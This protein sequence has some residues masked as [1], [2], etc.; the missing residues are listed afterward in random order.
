MP[1]NIIKESKNP[2]IKSLDGII[3]SG[4]VE[5]WIDTL[6]FSMERPILG[7]G[8]MADRIFLNYH[9]DG[10]KKFIEPVSNAYIY[11]LVSGG[12]PSLFLFGCECSYVTCLKLN[13]FDNFFFI[14]VNFP[15]KPDLRDKIG[16]C[17]LY[18]KRLFDCP[19]NSYSENIDPL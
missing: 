10:K 18:L 2:L 14:F 3:F 17:F 13:I 9:K 15:F 1:T 7:Y 6:K 4:R 19:I 16:I 12:I 11:A 8:S 5:L